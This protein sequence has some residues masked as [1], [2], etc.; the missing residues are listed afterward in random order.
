MKG[1]VPRLSSVAATSSQVA[2]EDLERV[3]LSLFDILMF[4]FMC[5]SVGRC[6]CHDFMW[7][8]GLELGAHTRQGL[9]QLGYILS[10]WIRIDFFLSHLSNLFEDRTIFILHLCVFCLAV[11]MICN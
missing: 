1:S 5:M 7:F 8:W 4:I 10:L 6:V 9:Y 11:G 2:V 3:D